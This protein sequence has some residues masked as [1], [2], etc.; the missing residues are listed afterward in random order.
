MTEKT[1]ENKRQNA[2]DQVVFVGNKPFMKLIGASL[3]TL[4]M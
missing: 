2:D 1:I 4:S 3:K